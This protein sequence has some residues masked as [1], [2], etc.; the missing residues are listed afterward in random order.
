MESRGNAPTY[1]EQGRNYV[2]GSLNWGPTTLLNAVYKTYGW[3]T[4]RRNSYDQA[5]HTYSLEWTE[6]WMRI[7]V[8]S[9]LHHLLDLRFNKPF[10]QRGDFPD[11]VQNGS[12]IVALQNPWAANATVANAAPFDQDFYLILNVAV[13]GTNGWFPDERGDKPWINN[14]RTAMADFA[15]AQDKW[16]STWPQGAEI[17][18][19]AMI[20]DSVKM[21]E[22]C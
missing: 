4:M 1:T 20:I 17:D 10:W 3:W 11:V 9:R 2:R 12:N 21:W 22:Q 19:R 14:A 16:Y 7:Y 5:F 6:D 8:D 15:K 13:G 18:D